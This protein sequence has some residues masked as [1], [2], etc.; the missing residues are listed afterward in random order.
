MPPVCVNLAVPPGRVIDCRVSEVR[1]LSELEV[2][3]QRSQVHWEEEWMKLMIEVL[4]WRRARMQD[5]GRIG[6]PHDSGVAH[7][8]IIPPPHA[9][10]MEIYE[11]NLRLTRLFVCDAPAVAAAVDS[12]TNQ[13]AWYDKPVGSVNDRTWNGWSSTEQNK[14]PCR[15]GCSKNYSPRIVTLCISSIESLSLL[16]N[17]FACWYIDQACVGHE[18]VALESKMLTL[19]WRSNSSGLFTQFDSVLRCYD[20]ESWIDLVGIVAVFICLRLDG[21]GQFTLSHQQYQYYLQCDYGWITSN[22]LIILL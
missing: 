6:V 13:P 11:W 3:Q 16:T 15:R 4:G 21:M 9:S 12:S 8:P 10:M 22:H 14:M 7:V 1:R 2:R 17:V 5:R 18:G 20:R 19:R